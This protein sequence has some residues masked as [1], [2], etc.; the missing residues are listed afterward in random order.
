MAWT[1]YTMGTRILVAISLF[2]V[3]FCF[4]WLKCFIIFYYEGDEI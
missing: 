1:I 2:Y 3:L 4:L